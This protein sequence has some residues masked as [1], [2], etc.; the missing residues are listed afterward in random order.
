MTEWTTAGEKK[1]KKKT[2]EGEQMPSWVDGAPN[3]YPALFLVYLLLFM[4]ERRHLNVR[5]L[6]VHQ[7]SKL[8][9]RL[10]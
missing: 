8:E 1:E 4:L 10:T 3:I 2:G 6:S 5:L 9:K 7:F